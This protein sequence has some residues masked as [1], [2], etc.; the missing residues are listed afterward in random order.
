M[1]TKNEKVGVLL[2]NLGTPDSPQTKDVRKYLREF[3]MDERVIDIPFLPRFVLVNGIIAPFRSPKSAKEYQKV[4][5]KNGSP[6][7]I[8]GL[9]AEKLLQEKLGKNFIVSL[10][11]RYQ[12]PSIKIALDKF[13]DKGISKLIV[14]PLYPQY[15]SATTGS[16]VQKVYEEVN[17][18]QIIPSMTIINQFL[19]H[20]S[21]IKAWVSI[22]K[23]I[24]EE[25]NYDHYL[26]SYHGLPERQIKKGS[27]SNYCQLNDKCCST[28]HSKNQYC[29]RAQCFETTRLLT[30]ALNIPEDK[31]TIC[32]QSRLGKQPWIQPYAEDT[33]HQVIKNGHKKVLT[34][35]PAFVAD[36]LET[37]IE[38][39]EEYKE[40]FM[41]LGG[42]KWQLVDSL[43]SHE[44]WISC[45][46]DL[47]LENQ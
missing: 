43:N 37:T 21:F 31:Y 29:Y 23:K 8:H 41:E 35:S 25:D 15:A 4:W 36:C 47:V 12:N 44:D 18:W 13:K 6:L 20:P 14:L 22:A 30:E 1:S 28:F 17:K 19:E 3:L 11:M 45:L 32:F 9:A 10:G 38:V 16:T 7:L 40:L 2:V 34:F 5:T 26:F 27:C 39:G 33:I 24:M 46:Q 42:E